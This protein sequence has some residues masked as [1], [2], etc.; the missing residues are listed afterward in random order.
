MKYEYFIKIIKI[1]E[2]NLDKWEVFNG[3]P[4]YAHLLNKNIKFKYSDFQMILYAFHLV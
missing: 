2:A 3:N 1:L 4:T